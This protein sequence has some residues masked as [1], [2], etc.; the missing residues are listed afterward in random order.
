MPNINIKDFPSPY[1]SGGKFDYCTKIEKFF[2][3]IL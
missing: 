3:N 2:S 1:K